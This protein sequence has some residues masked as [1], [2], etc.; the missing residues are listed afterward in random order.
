MQQLAD[1]ETLEAFVALAECSS[2]AR[3]GRRLGRDP[4]IVSRRLQA[5]ESRLGVR[6]AERSTRRVTLTEAGRSYLDRIRPLL[7]EL[8]AADRDAA[9]FARGQPRGHLRLSLPTSFGRMWLSPMIAAF[10]QAHPGVTIEA[11]LSNRFVDLIGEGFDL[12]VRLGV[13]PDS[14]L[15]ARRLLGRG[16]LVCAAP[17]YLARAPALKTPADLRQH[18][19]LCYTGKANPTAWEFLDAEERLVTVPIDGALASDDAEILV[20]AAVAGLGLVYATEWLVARQLASGLLVR[21]L[22][23]WRIADEGAIYVV[24]PSLGGLPTK[25]RAFSDWLAGRFQP[26][27]PWA[28]ARLRDLADH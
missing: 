17:D 20:D 12:A 28:P 11:V 23:D 15:V 10:L 22:T 26:D 21:V 1:I 6:L 7:R 9:S 25:T 18:A 14:R 8:A 13:L 2:F 3:A 5:L 4:T 27:P 24:T 19:C 16:R